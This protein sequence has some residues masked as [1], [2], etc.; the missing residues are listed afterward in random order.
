MTTRRAFL[1]NMLFRSEITK[2]KFAQLT[3]PNGNPVYI[4]SSIIVTRSSDRKGLTLLR[5][6]M[7]SQEVKESPETVVRALELLEE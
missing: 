4:G 6:P 2:T 1:G 7:G 3:A 5:T